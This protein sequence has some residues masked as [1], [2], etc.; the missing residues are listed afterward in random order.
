MMPWQERDKRGICR[1]FQTLLSA[2]VIA[3]EVLLRARYE[4]VGIWAVMCGLTGPD[5]SW[6]GLLPL[7]ATSPCWAP[8]LHSAPTA[9]LPRLPQS[10][11]ERRFRRRKLRRAWLPSSVR[12]HKSFLIV[13]KNHQYSPRFFPPSPNRYFSRRSDPEEAA[14]CFSWPSTETPWWTGNRGALGTYLRGIISNLK[15]VKHVD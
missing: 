2:T 11:E 7:W 9:F 3:M 15:D 12:V 10:P 14:K 4:V 1:L 5:P 13:T 8:C 6:A